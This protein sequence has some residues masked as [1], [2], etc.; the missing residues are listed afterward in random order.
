LLIV[1]IGRAAWRQQPMWGSTKEL[2]A[3]LAPPYLQGFPWL[4]AAIGTG[5][6][7]TAIRLIVRSRA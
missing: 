7:I 3:A 2:V 5:I 1:V 4:A 6:A